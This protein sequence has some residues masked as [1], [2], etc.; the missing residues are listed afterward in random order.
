MTLHEHATARSPPA[1]PRMRWAA[2][3]WLAIWIPA[4]AWTW[5]W[6]N[7]LHLCDVA[8]VLTCV[9]L[10]RGSALLLSSQ[11]V[12]SIVVDAFWALDAGWR[13]FSGKHLVGGTEYMWDAHYPLFVRLLSLFHIFSP[14]LLIWSL[15]RVG[16]NRRGF[17]LQVAIALCLLVASRFLG[18]A[19]N[20]NFAFRDP[21]LH[22]SWGPAPVHLS[23]ILSFLVGGV[24]LPVH[25]GLVHL[26]A[27][28]R[29]L[30]I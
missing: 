10:W 21:L 13:L 20:I 2:M 12:S 28:P 23:L 7:F 25:L 5:G 14:A 17:P 22:R 6:P 8:V 19:S 30:R 16:Y 26:L 24:Y 11:A 4:Y 15:R 9:G 29:R 18:Q 1:F 3:T 27:P